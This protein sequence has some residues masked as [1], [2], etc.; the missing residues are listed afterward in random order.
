MVSGGAALDTQR[1]R[2]HEGFNLLRGNWRDFS[3][4]IMP[5]HLGSSR[6]GPDPTIPA[7]DPV[8]PGSPRDCPRQQA[9]T[10]DHRA[11]SM[12]GFISALL[13]SFLAKSLPD[14]QSSWILDCNSSRTLHL[15]QSVPIHLH[16]SFCYVQNS[17]LCSAD[18]TNQSLPPHLKQSCFP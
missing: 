5:H 10:Q 13:I 8:E 7:Q 17:M 18:S 16:N 6:E 9:D 1:S 15:P 4:L 14:I 2:H 3:K 11:V 12:T